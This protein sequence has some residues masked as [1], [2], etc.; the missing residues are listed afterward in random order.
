[1]PLIV[2]PCLSPPETAKMIGSRAV[3][4]AGG[5]LPTFPLDELPPDKRFLPIEI[6]REEYRRGTLP[7]KISLTL[8]GGKTVTKSFTEF[9]RPP[10]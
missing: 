5:H 4:I 3:Q 8:P 1:M 2:R 10:E 9:Y 7:I 6:A